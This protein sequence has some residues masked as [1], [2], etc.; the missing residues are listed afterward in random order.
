MNAFLELTKMKEFVFIVIY[1]GGVLIA[2]CLLPI[3][4]PRLSIHH[5]SD[6]KK[7]IVVFITLILMGI[8]VFLY[9]R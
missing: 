7:Y 4:N 9:L 8:A 1:G 2:R 6:R 3:I 5:L